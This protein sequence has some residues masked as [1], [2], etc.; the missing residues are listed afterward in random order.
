M[1]QA[2]VDLVKDFLAR[3]LLA[4]GLHHLL[5]LDPLVD[6]GCLLPPGSRSAGGSISRSCGD[7]A[8]GEDAQGG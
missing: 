7:K 5:P 8:G 2:A 6:K 1:L 3:P 4:E